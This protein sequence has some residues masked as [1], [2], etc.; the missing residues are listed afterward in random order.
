MKPSFRRKFYSSLAEDDFRRL[1][2]SFCLVSYLDKKTAFER[3][4]AKK[5]AVAASKLDRAKVDPDDFV[6]DLADSISILVRE[7]DVYSFLHRSFQ[8]YF[9]AVFLAE[10]QIPKMEE[11]FLPIV[12]RNETDSVIALLREMNNEA[13]ENKYL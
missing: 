9:S 13:F 4:F 10:R 1:F 7:G 12:A 5:Y 2:S 6:R 11:F 8:E 3:G